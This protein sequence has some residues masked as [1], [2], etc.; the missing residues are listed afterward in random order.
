MTNIYILLNKWNNKNKKPNEK[1]LEG[2][3]EIF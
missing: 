3:K 2:A 1:P